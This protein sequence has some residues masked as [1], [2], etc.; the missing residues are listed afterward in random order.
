MYNHGYHKTCNIFM[1][2]NIRLG[3]D[4]AIEPEQLLVC[5]L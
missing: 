5:H 2:D 1:V 4:E 3:G